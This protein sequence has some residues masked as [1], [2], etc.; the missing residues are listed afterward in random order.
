MQGLSERSTYFR[1][2]AVPRSADREVHRLLA[3]DGDQSTALVAE[4][5][6]RIVGVASYVRLPRQPGHAEVAFAVADVAQGHGI[7][8]QLLVALSAVARQAGIDTFEA[9]VLGDNH[10]MLQVFRGSGFTIRLNLDAGVYH[11]TLDLSATPAVE[12]QAATRARTAA[13]ASMGPFFAPRSV[14]VIGAS[15]QRGKIGAEVLHNLIASGFTGRLFAVHPSAAEIQG[16]P[17]S[18]RVTLLP[19]APDLAVICVPAGDVRAVVD[20]CIA[21]GVKALVVITAGFAE[22]GEAGR[23]LE[24]DL[25]AA[26]RRAGIRM[27]GPNCMGVLNT[28]PA[29][30][31]NAT[32]S[33]VFP[34]VG[35]VAMLSQSG[36]LGLAI[37]DH[38][39][40]LQIGLST[41]VSVGNKAD[42]SGND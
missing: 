34:P 28:D 11:L 23:H 36:A 20:D 17:A 38:A 31:L 15:Q 3:C 25:L 27:I 35:R 42:V 22:T 33:P 4:F 39:G 7:G 12:A 13:A 8:T 10:E 9:D 16:V 5:A 37:L 30:R 29:T 32:F 19:E 14:V 41:F 6:G 24:A 40:R 2:F 1:F 26:V 18:P 21:R